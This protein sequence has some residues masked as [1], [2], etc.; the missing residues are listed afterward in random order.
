M[1]KIILADDDSDDCELFQDALRE[2]GIQ[3]QITILKMELY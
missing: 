1:K 3:T 2:V